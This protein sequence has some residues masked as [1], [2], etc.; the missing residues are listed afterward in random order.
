M[1]DIQRDVTTFIVD[2][3]LFGNVADAPAPGSSFMETGLIDSTG[4]LELV[5]FVEDRYGIKV[6]DDEL[7][8]ENLDSVQ[9]IA[10]FVSRKRGS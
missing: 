7:V 2:N 3:F 8:P 9:N 5:G 4:I 1:Q 6:G 10:A